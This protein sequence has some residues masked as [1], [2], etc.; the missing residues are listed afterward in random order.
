[1]PRIL[2]TS[3]F[4][5]P[6]GI[7]ATPAVYRGESAD[8]RAALACLICE[9]WHDGSVYVH[10]DF[11]FFQNEM[12]GAL[13]TGSIEGSCWEWHSAYGIVE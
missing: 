13:H 5:V 2:R 7:I 3:L 12:Q 4:F 6:L 1:M 8:A 10:Q 11:Q 9:E